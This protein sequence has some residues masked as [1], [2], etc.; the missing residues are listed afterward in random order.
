M[1]SP[2]VFPISLRML[3]CFMVV[4]LSGICSMHSHERRA[5]LASL[6]A[7]GPLLSR[8]AISESHTGIR[9]NIGND[10]L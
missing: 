7:T 3:V 1:F 10:R 5:R 6:S 4:V 2:L 9:I 8:D